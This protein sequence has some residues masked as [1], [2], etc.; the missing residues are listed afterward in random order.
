MKGIMEMFTLVFEEDEL[1]ELD[2][3][4]NGNFSMEGIFDYMS[5]TGMGYEESIAFLTALDKI[6]KAAN[7]MRA[8][9][10]RCGE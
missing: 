2:L 1:K 8:E 7:K 5:R 9:L 10:E 3:F 6:D 4:V